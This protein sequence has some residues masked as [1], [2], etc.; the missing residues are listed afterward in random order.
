MPLHTLQTTP[1]PDPRN[2]LS[3]TLAAAF[4]ARPSLRAVGRQLLARLLEEAFP[5]LLCDVSAL[6]LYVPEGEHF[7]K[8]PLLD[9]ALDNLCHWEPLE[10]D[11]A[12]GLVGYLGDGGHTVLKYQ[13]AWLPAGEVRT[14]LKVFAEELLAA[15]QQAL[16]DYWQAT[17]SQG[18]SRLSGLSLT[19]AQA[20]AP[21]ARSHQRWA[22]MVSQ[23]LLCAH[24]QARREQ[25]G[26]AAVEACLVNVQVT[27]QSRSDTLLLADLLL[28][29]GD[30]VLWCK[31]DGQARGF[32]AQA[33]FARALA[34]ELEATYPVAGLSWQRVEIEQNVFVVQAEALLNQQLQDIAALRVQGSTVSALEQAFA[35][36]TD[37]SLR[38]SGNRALALRDHSLSAHVPQW[39]QQASALDY[40]A[41]QAYWMSLVQAQLSSAGKSFDHDIPSLRDYAAQRLREAML[42]DHPDSRVDPYHLVLTFHVPYGQGGFGFVEKV[43][44][45]FVDAA[46]ENLAGLPKGTLVLSLDSEQAPPDW[47]TPA[48][49]KALIQRVDVGAG[50]PQL[51]EQQLH[52]D[53]A[54]RAVRQRL[55]S[56]QLRAQLPLLALEHKIKREHGF[57]REGYRCVSYAMSTTR[58]AAVSVRPLTFLAGADAAADVVSN[59][60]V[61]KRPD[62]AVLVLYRPLFEPVLQQFA[63]E[64]ALFKALK[65][66]T[67][68][69]SVLNWMSDSARPVYDHDGF[70]HPHLG[71]AVDDDFIVLPGN[72]PRLGGTPLAGDLL[73]H[74]YQANLDALKRL[75]DRQSTS[76]AESRWA[77]VKEGGWLLFNIVLPLVRGPAAVAGWLL[78]LVSSLENDLSQLSHGNDEERAQALVDLLFNLATLF[79]HG[80][81][82]IDSVRQPGPALKPVPADML[83]Q[84]PP[85]RV[86]GSAPTTGMVLP[87]LLPQVL[88]VGQAEQLNTALEFSWRARH[89]SPSVH[90][91]RLLD[92]LQVQ[93]G[94]RAS[95]RVDSGAGKGLLR[96]GSELYVQI[97]RQ[98]FRVVQQGDGFYIADPQAP[99]GAR[100]GPWLRLDENDQWQLD[101]RLR[102]RGGGPKSRLSLAQRKLE[103][104]Q[105]M[106]EVPARMAVAQHTCASAGLANLPRLNVLDSRLAVLFK[107]QRAYQVDRSASRLVELKLARELAKNAEQAYVADQDA[108][109][110]QVEGLL[111]LCLEAEDTYKAADRFGLIKSADYRARRVVLYKA[112]AQAR[113][114]LQSQYHSKSFKIALNDAWF[115]NAFAVTLGE[116]PLPGSALAE[117][118]AAL[119]HYHQLALA[120]SEAVD[121]ML[122]ELKA[123]PA[124]REQAGE[125]EADIA[126]RRVQLKTVSTVQLRTGYMEMLAYMCLD[127][128]IAD[129]EQRQQ[130]KQRLTDPEVFAGV[131]SREQMSVDPAAFTAQE[132]AAVLEEALSCYSRARASALYVAEL[133]PPVAGKDY[134]AIYLEVVERLRLSAEQELG[135]LLVAPPA[136]PARP[137]PARKY[138]VIHTRSR[139]VLVGRRREPV[140]GEPGE[141]V[142]IDSASGE[143]VVATFREHASDDWNEVKS[144]LPAP[145]T[146][147]KSRKALRRVGRQ[148]LDRMAAL[149][150]KQ[151][152]FIDSEHAP[153]DIAY[154]L[155]ALAHNL[156]DVAAQF[157]RHEGLLAAEQ[158]F[159]EELAT[160]AQALR[161][162]AR[163]IRVRMC[164]AQKPTA[165]NLLY[166]W[167]Q[168]QVKIVA[169][170]ARKPLKAGDLIDEYE[171]SIRGGGTWYVHLHYPALQTPVQAFSKGHIKLAAQRLLGYA[172]LLKN[173]NSRGALPEIWRA[174]LTPMFI[175]GWFPLRA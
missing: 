129:L 44:L 30:D 70:A 41:Y 161:T 3:T 114:Q 144:V 64:A 45:L 130:F 77:M 122:V 121:Q 157:Q 19:L 102:L 106:Q 1:E 48:Y 159:V 32:T 150:L 20:L 175:K 50:Y 76:N 94:E 127:T 36:V 156:G 123:D 171:V 74:L 83:T 49:V 101:L 96:V 12:S 174:D 22:P 88:K 40:F 109:I 73:L 104:A 90:L 35:R 131:L 107:Q 84:G 53:S 34:A 145:S 99:H 66:K 2:V 91:Q 54:Q 29:R 132:R 110:K 167:E 139:R 100:R 142:D 158:A 21:Q 14:V 128:R 46:L 133:Y 108:Y 47:L 143:R 65:H 147:L 18:V 86:A 95:V 43:P 62:S 55:F 163:D 97:E 60:F 166:L 85:A 118:Y 103:A 59:M 120:M 5:G 11:A 7:A 162:A 13:G 67:L 78:Q 160:A 69:D 98:V 140:A 134:L 93:I 25:Y 37:L 124:L 105:K 26:A 17:G 111:A 154:P 63:D 61:L 31:P 115:E 38:L 24:Q 33:D 23:V 81:G 165:R 116:T 52:A 119:E 10:F 173:A 8:R 75:A 148:Y 112:Q 169:L 164:K 149:T 125:V 79:M 58:A 151:Q 56:E 87:V 27:T 72:T 51:L 138:K 117:A 68:A 89:P 146:G 16:I 136:V 153:A 141:V 57:T 82:G 126:S 28:V 155:E 168:K 113:L 9:A 80:V 152:G 170:G 172:D 6:Y 4:D 15:C 137:V 71:V 42:S 92:A 135:A 39:L